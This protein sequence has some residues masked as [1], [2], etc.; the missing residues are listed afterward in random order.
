MNRITIQA[1]DVLYRRIRDGNKEAFDLLFV[2]YYPSLCSYAGQFVSFE[3]SEEIVQDIMLWVWKD[4][5]DNPINYS[6]KQY[7]YKMVKNRCL[8]LIERDKVKEKVNSALYNEMTDVFND[9]DFYIMDELVTKIE[10]ALSQLP[11]TYRVAFEKNRFEE[12]TYKEIAAELNISPKTVDYRIQQSLKIL[13][14]KLKDYL[15]LIT[16]L[17]F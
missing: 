14:I 3:D 13:R 15:P 2:K 1:D 16:F 17:G 10:E 6:L 5:E 11:E 12:K 9:P 4:R 8:N 7:L